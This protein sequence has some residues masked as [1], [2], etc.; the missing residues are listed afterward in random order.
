MNG[1]SHPP[2]D[3]RPYTYWFWP[4]SAVTEEEITWELQQMHE[5]GMGGVLINSAFGPVFEKGAIPF[6][7]DDHLKMIRHA[8]LTAKKLGMKVVLNFSGGW[9]FGGFWLPPEQRSQSL[10]PASVELNGPVHFS[11]ELPKFVKAADHRGE[12]SVT[13]I[14]DGEKLV[15]V[16]AGKIKDGNMPSSTLVDLT[17]LVVNDSLNWTVPEGLWRLTAFWLKYTGQKTVPPDYG[18]VHW[19]V[20]HFSRSAMKNYCEFIGGKYF[21]AVGDEFGKTISALHCDSFEMASLPDGFYWSD[22]LLTEFHAYKGYE[23]TR[24]LPALWWSVDDLSAKIRYDVNDFLHHAGLQIFFRTFL[25]WCHRHGIQASMEPYGFTTD[26]LEGAGMVDLPFMEVTPGEK[27]AVPWF[28]TRIG[29]KRYVASGADLYG[30]NIIG[31][32]AYT[33]LHWEIYRATLEELKI[34]SAGFLCTGANHFFNH[35]Y[36]YTPERQAAPSRTLPW[37]AV[38]NHTNLWWS[39]YHH[40]ADYVGRCCFLLRQGRPQKDIAVY[41]P[42]ANQWTLD[43][44]NARKWTREYDWGVL[45]ELIF[46]NGY[47]F[48]LINDE[49]LQHRASWQNGIL[50]VNAMEYRILLLPDISAMPVETLQI[51]RRYVA[52]GG[53]VIALEQLPACSV[54]LHDH[55]ANDLRVQSLI[56]EM[57][58]EP[59]SPDGTGEKPFG[60]GRTHFI[61]R[62]LRRHDVL[63]R[64]SSPLDP[65]VNTLRTYLSPDVSID[66]TAAG[67][68]EN[69]GLSFFH[70]RLGEVD[71]YF[72]ANIQERSFRLPLTFRVRDKIP[73][74][75]NPYDGSISRLWHYRQNSQGIELPIEL[76]PFESLF[77]LFQ[78]G[79]DSSRVLASDF[80]RIVNMKQDT[81]F[82]AARLN[83]RHHLLVQ[84]RRRIASFSCTVQG[85][86]PPL[87]LTGPWKMTLAEAGIDTLLTHL[88]S[89]TAHPA[90]RHFSGIGCYEIQFTLP[91]GYLNKQLRLWLDLG[92]VGSIAHVQ[93][94][95][96]PIGTQWISHTYLPITSAIRP[97]NN[98]LVVEVTNTLINRAAALKQ[99]VPVPAKLIPHYGSGITAYTKSFR[100]PVGFAALP[101]SG[102]IGPV[103]IIAEKITSIPVR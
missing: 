84:S 97:G 54:G 95:G 67:L 23:L 91:A 57:F 80:H 12:I 9:V 85:V 47:Q 11:A 44:K 70:R 94:N 16:V 30:R 7:S 52:D 92:K 27:D 100:G 26:I 21:Q 31:V 90:I 49:V 82:A 78:S 4:A 29:P 50:T 56:H 76:A 83:G 101:A 13:D 1:F 98:R 39:D 36:A 22:S 61:K 25:E 46:A 68:R 86:P 96:R 40:L 75:W 42:L 63:D 41:S 64:L 103:H 19:C 15:A 51:I 93:L 71:L 59:I 6:L 69:N 58:T 37:A 20:D 73:W 45:G 35:L 32:E 77:V 60:K 87:K 102:L 34:A 2:R 99:P 17:S 8:V 88:E 38:I 72:V 66:L 33:Y 62:V 53:V 10:V 28:D 55:V 3:C 81:I 43:V 18:Q 14:P 5:Q 74:H 79:Q 24:Y 48:D 65:F 89:W